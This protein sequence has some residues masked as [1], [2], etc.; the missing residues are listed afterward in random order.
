MALFDIP[1][2][3]GMRPVDLEPELVNSI[4][5]HH[6]LPTAITDLVDNSLDAEARNIRVRF[7]LAQA[8]PVGLQ[9]IDNGRGMDSDRLDRAMTYSGT[10]QYSDSDLGHFGVGLKAASLSQARTVLVYTRA[11]DSEV[12]GRVLVR[13]SNGKT[14]QVG[15]FDRAQS[16][17]RYRALD[18]EFEMGSGTV[19]EWRDVQA[20]PATRNSRERSRWLQET[21]QDVRRHLGLILHRIL[22]SRTLDLSVDTLDLRTGTRGPA[23]TVIPIDPFGYRT[24][25]DQEFP[26]KLSIDMPDGSCPVVATS[27]IWPARSQDPGFKLGG[28]PGDQAQ[29]FFI[30]RRDRLLQVG[31][32]CGMWG[33]RQEWG[34]ARVAVDATEDSVSHLTINPEKSGITL[35][36][37]L[38]R[39][40]ETSTCQGSELTFGDFLARAADED[41]R[42]R[43]RTRRPVTVV[44]PRFGIPDSVVAAYRESVEFNP[45]YPAVDIDWVALPPDKV[46]EI[47]LDDRVLELNMKFRHAL[48]ADAHGSEAPLVTTLMHLLLQHLFAGLWLGAKDKL[49]MK[50]WNAILLAAVQT[51]YPPHGQRL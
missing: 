45:N 34:L 44:E 5:L 31:G 32:W 2:S 40:I 47:N 29:G 43:M 41:R 42:S 16:E 12:V 10:R 49:E 1:A 4:G 51:E 38:R 11:T 20:F 7:L 25:G 6:T 24:S 36:P 17:H 18:V 27:H 8:A 26:T 35:S 19:V 9:V 28:R 13:G 39:A 22:S 14:P 15:D 37:D 23:R 3:H 48:G 33:A 50:A 21:I 46:F 30:Y